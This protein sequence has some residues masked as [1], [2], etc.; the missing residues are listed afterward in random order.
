[1][2]RLFDPFPKILSFILSTDTLPARSLSSSFMAISVKYSL[3]S[4]SYLSNNFCRLFPIISEIWCRVR[5]PSSK[6]L[7]PL[8]MAVNFYSG[9]LR[10]E[11]LMILMNCY[12]LM[13]SP[14]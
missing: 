10:R 2:V 14:K 8:R 12:Q 1:M 9:V 11:M 13:K 7:I 4:F 6:E 5:K 3:S